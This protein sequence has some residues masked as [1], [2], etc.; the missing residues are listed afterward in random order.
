MEWAADSPPVA[1]VVHAQVQDLRVLPLHA[2][3]LGH[4]AVRT[5]AVLA[6]G[7][8]VPASLGCRDELI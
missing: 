7:L 2:Q 8:H 6:A 3:E 1:E 5:H 4:R